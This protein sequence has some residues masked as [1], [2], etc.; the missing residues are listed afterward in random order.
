MVSDSFKFPEPFEKLTI[1]S[2]LR[3]AKESLD[4][5]IKDKQD[6]IK[7]LKEIYKEIE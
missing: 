6:E 5:L 3:P 7:S 4:M 2:Y 1:S